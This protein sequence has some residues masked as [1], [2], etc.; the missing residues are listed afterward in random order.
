MGLHRFRRV[1]LPSG[2]IALLIG[3]AA[4]AVATQ[5]AAVA[6]PSSSAVA[7]A[8]RHVPTPTSPRSGKWV[9]HLTGTAAAKANRVSASI[10]TAMRKARLKSGNLGTRH[11]SP[12]MN[13]WSNSLHTNWGTIPTQIF[14]GMFATQSINSFTLSDSDVVF[15][16]T[17]DPS[18]DSCIEVTTRYQSGENYL[19]AW[20]WCT[21]SPGWA[22]SWPDLSA[23]FQANYTTTINGQPFYTIEI[24]NTNSQENQWTA[25]LYNYLTG[26][27]DTFYQTSGTSQLASNGVDGWDMDEVY[28]Y[29]NSSTGEGDYCAAAEGAN[30]E[31]RS[32][33][34]ETP[35]GSWGNATNSNSKPAVAFPSGNRVG[36]DNGHFW[37]P[38]ENSNWRVTLD[39]HGAGSIAG[40]GSGRC[41]DVYNSN[42]SNAAEVD[43]WDCNGTGAQSWSYTSEGAL[44]IDG[45]KYCL[46][47]ANS[48]TA[49]GTGVR[50]WT[51]NGTQTQEWTWSIHNTLV[52]INS[53]RCLDA[54]NYGT[55]N[56]TM[57]QIYDCKATTNQQWTWK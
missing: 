6:S 10:A 16:P 40:T 2:I 41:L 21:T 11:A 54:I 17:M 37:L 15:S 30:F 1:M 20:D 12:A 7:T 33:E 36:C 51:C 44:T 27:Y 38:A 5:A 50:L 47:V 35:A 52:G 56:G 43:I 3:V 28:T 31:S 32:L 19:S 55:A 13:Q 24:V 48:H 25:Y 9:P 49:N 8:T 4:P 39:T 34:L 22:V 46:D 23:S 57:L 45:G 18:P 53:G 14:D 29:W 26:A 42:F